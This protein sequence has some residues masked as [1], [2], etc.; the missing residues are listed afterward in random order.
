MNQVHKPQNALLHQKL[1]Q[2][3][4]DGVVP[5]IEELIVEGCDQGLF[6]SQYPREAA[7]MVMIYS[8]IAFDDLAEL[9]E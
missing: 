2:R 8:N 6:H 9:S 1:Q 7:E 4:I 3:M 5:L